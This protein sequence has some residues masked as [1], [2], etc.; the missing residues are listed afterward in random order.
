MCLH[1]PSAMFWKR[2]KK[3]SEPSL[4]GTGTLHDL[5]HQV[6]LLRGAVEDLDDRFRRFSA[7]ARKRW[8]VDESDD[9]AP[10]NGA[11]RDA[12]PAPRAALPT[13]G[14]LRATGRWPMR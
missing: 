10:A 9:A 11:A 8:S 7:R 4:P 13:L 6:F 1:L 12:P 3:E 2:S 14:Q 5:E